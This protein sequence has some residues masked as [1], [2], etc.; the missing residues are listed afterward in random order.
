MQETNSNDELLARLIRRGATMEQVARVK[1]PIANTP[2]EALLALKKGNARFFSGAPE[3]VFSDIN[4]RRTQIIAQTP[5]AVV[6]GCADSRVPVEIIFDQGPGD[7]F[8]IRVA[9]NV[10]SPGALGSVQYAIRHLKVRLLVVMGHEGC[11]AVE[12]AI[13][14]SPEQREAEPLHVRFLL[15]TIAPS[16]S[17]VPEILD[18]NERMRE[19]VTRNVRHQKAAFEADD[20]V[21]SAVDSGH[22]RV[23]GAY[24]EIGSGAVDF[25]D[26]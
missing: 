8:S 4:E 12:A 11:G 5:F 23:V 21:K 6:V 20:F 18:T 9:G 2:D 17:A 15:E 1:D 14:M 24:Y 22:L 3:R 19:A 10:L 16:S 25:L 13:S 26:E 7:I